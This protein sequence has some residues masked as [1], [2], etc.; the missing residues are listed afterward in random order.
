MQH[1]PT[2]SLQQT[3]NCSLHAGYAADHAEA[4][5][6]TKY[7]NLTDRYIFQPIAVETTGV[8]GNS[9]MSFL[10]ELGRK[11]ATETG[12]KRESA[13]PRQRLSIAV[14]RGNALSVTTSAKNR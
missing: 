7:Q 9:T 5:K 12:D 3:N 13:W 8:L 14:A 2:L 10:K 6:V 11:M 1:A 4:A